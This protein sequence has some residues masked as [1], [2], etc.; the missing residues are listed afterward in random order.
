MFKCYYLVVSSLVVGVWMKCKVMK[1]A[2]VDAV[3]DAHSY[4]NGSCDGW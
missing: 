1:E 4:I 2:I 3:L